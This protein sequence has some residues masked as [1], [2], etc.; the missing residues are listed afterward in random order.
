MTSGTTTGSRSRTLRKK[1][2]RAE[3]IFSLSF[4]VSPGAM[5]SNTSNTMHL[6]SSKQ[7]RIILFKDEALGDDIRSQGYFARGLVDDQQDDDHAF[8]GQKLAFLENRLAY[9]AHA[10]SVHQDH[11]R[12]DGFLESHSLF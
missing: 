10:F 9:V 5:F 4:F 11:V 7:V 3:R 6:A 2:R 1:R 8:P 12:R